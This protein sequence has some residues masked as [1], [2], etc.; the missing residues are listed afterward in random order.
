M[1]KLAYIALVEALS[2]YLVG[3]VIVELPNFQGI[4]D[5]GKLYVALVGERAFG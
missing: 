3:A 4:C 2:V 1:I 5:F